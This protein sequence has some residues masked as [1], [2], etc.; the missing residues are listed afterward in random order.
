M[1]GSIAP[2]AMAWQMRMG[3]IAGPLSASGEASNE[4][5]VQ[6]ELYINGAWVDITSY[7]MVRDESGNISVTRGRRDEA[8]TTEQSTC[9]LLLNNRD[10][11]WSPRYPAGAYYGLIGRNTPI[12]VSVPN[13]LGGKSYRFQ[14]EVSVWPQGWDPTGTDVYTEIQANGILRRLSQGPAPAY[15]LMR[16]ALGTY[17]TANLRAYWPG[18]DAEGSTTLASV[19]TTGSVMTW[20]GSPARHLPPGRRT[21]DD[22][23]ARSAAPHRTH[24]ERLRHQRPL[25]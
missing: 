20:T 11:R 19:L 16:T 18:E 25:V 7:V 2:L 21:S 4:Q 14:G 1:P 22:T 8:S 12:R 9:T 3:G 15:S 10:G 24:G 5:P 6:V 17:P 23:R 13:G